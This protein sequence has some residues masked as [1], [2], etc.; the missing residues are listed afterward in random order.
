MPKWN[1]VAMGQAQWR[2][3]RLLRRGTAVTYDVVW[4]SPVTTTR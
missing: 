2:H 3:L 4:L 1:L